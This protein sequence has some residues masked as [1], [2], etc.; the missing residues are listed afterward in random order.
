[1]LRDSVNNDQSQMDDAIMYSNIEEEA[2]YSAPPSTPIKVPDNYIV[3][4]PRSISQLSSN[5]TMSPRDSMSSGSSRG[6]SSISENAMFMQEEDTYNVP[7]NLRDNTNTF[8]I[9][10]TDA[11]NTFRIK[12]DI[13]TA[14]NYENDNENDDLSLPS[15]VTSGGCLLYT[16]PSPRDGLLSRMPSSA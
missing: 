1:M 14:S 11:M 10:D 9:K 6:S 3:E 15:A 2:L 4:K 16:S 5:A 12:G 13:D 7:N 8:I